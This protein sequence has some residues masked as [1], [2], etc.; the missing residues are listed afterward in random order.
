[1]P[2]AGTA[3]KALRKTQKLSLR[4]VAELAEVDY[5]TLS[6]VERGQVEPSAR[7]LKAVTDALGKHI[8]ERV[9]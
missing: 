7:W 3:L 4:Q 9:A 8:A 1:M 2:H 6:K 5:S